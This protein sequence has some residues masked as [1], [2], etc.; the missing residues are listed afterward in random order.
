MS[1][2]WEL[3]TLHGGIRCTTEPVICLNKQGMPVF[4]GTVMI[5]CNST[6]C[7]AGALER[8]KPVKH[9]HYA[10]VLICELV[11]NKWSYKCIGLRDERFEL[12]RLKRK[13]DAS[14]VDI[15]EGHACMTSMM[16]PDRYT[17]CE[18]CEC[19]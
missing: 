18:E 15:A 9:I 19:V 2:T 8:D 3:I 5:I 13:E 11:H 10:E 17:L 14:C 1:Y 6:T 4:M 12:S 7:R 16:S